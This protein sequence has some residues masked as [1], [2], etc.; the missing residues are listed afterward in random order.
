MGFGNL[1][2]GPPTCRST[3]TY[4]VNPQLSTVFKYKA[5]LLCQVGRCLVSSFAQF[6]ELVVILQA[7]CVCVRCQDL[8][9]TLL[10]WSTFFREASYVASL[11][12]LA[13]CFNRPETIN[14]VDLLLDIVQ[15]TSCSFPWAAAD[16]SVLSFR[17]SY[18]TLPGW[19]HWTFP[20]GFLNSIHLRLVL[21]L[22]I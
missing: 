6:H 3:L 11:G 4:G 20:T 22:G 18:T 12:I 19:A 15:R 1:N 14:A 7:S 16:H 13:G 8:S 21:E 5:L 9:Q 2:P 10:S 17:A